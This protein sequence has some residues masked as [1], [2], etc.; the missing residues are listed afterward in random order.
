MG[1][2]RELS[3]AEIVLSDD[4]WRSLRRPLPAV[5][6]Y[7]REH[8]DLPGLRWRRVTP[9]PLG[10]PSMA[11]FGTGHDLFGDGSL[12][13]LPTPGHTPG[14]LSLLVRRPAR[15]PLLLVGDLTYDADLLAA[16]EIPGVGNKRQLRQAVADVNAL[17]DRL[18]GLTVL[19]AHDPGAADLLTGALTM[20]A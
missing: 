16:G 15:A 17:R 19:A 6:G 14:S 5:R 3:G 1:G 12:L 20:A 2:L 11:P 13:L 9:E 4:E 10:D 18:P 7:L 8:I